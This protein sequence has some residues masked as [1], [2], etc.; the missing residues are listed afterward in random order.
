MSDSRDIASLRKWAPLGV[1][2][3]ITDCSGADIFNV[4]RLLGS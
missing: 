1:P 3:G 4:L 2:V